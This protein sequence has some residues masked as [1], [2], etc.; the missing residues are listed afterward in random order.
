MNLSETLT[1]TDIRQLH[2]LAKVW[3]CECN[4]HSKNEL[5][6]SL[7]H[8]LTNK[9]QIHQEF[10]ELSPPE[11]RFLFNLVYENPKEYL[12]DAVY[13]K[14]RQAYKEDGESG[15][16]RKMLERALEK[17]WLFRISMG[18]DEKFILPDEVRK[19]WCSLFLPQ[20]QAIGEEE[21]TV[22]TLYNGTH[23]MAND[24][25]TLLSYFM[26]NRVQIAKNGS[27]YRKYVSKILELCH[28]QEELPTDEW[29]FGY[30]RR[31]R[32]YPDRF[33]LLYDYA[34]HRQWI[35]EDGVYGVIYLT[36]QGRQRLEQGII[37]E[38]LTK[39][40]LSYWKLTYRKAIPNIEN[41]YRFISL[42]CKDQW[43]EEKGL[44]QNLLPFT[45]PFFYDRSEDVIRK[46]ILNMMTYF[47]VLFKVTLIDGT[48]AYY[49]IPEGEN[50]LWRR[51]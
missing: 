23:H 31:F 12:K 50:G 45:S 19:Q 18:Q 22:G 32:E 44:L 14:A 48:F 43:I 28:V 9:Y 51:K 15:K 46:R 41:I 49:F 34:F 6:Q 17:G 5:I 47:G 36:D 29:R 7:F 24:L 38:E 35:E 11:K 2:Y 33:S 16:H 3:N 30:G 1:Y 39:N 20:V 27:M 25:I 26:E 10:L 8:H 40:L 21:I 42:L 37:L 13:A 4:I